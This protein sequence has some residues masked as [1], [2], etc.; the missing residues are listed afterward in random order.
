MIDLLAQGF[1]FDD[2]GAGGAASADAATRR[3]NTVAFQDS[4]GPCA[5]RSCRNCQT[6]FEQEGRTV[7][8][9]ECCQPKPFLAPNK[10][11]T[12]A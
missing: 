12:N 5:N 7:D 8:K 9:H 1:G 2:C 6:R 10:K 4:T 3:D 11:S